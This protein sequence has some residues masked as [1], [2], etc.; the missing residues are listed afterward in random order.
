MTPFTFQTTP[1]VL[2]EPG[3]AQKIAGLVSGFEEDVG[4]GLEGE[5]FHRWPAS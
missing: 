1:N 2:F 5:R 3:A 4:G